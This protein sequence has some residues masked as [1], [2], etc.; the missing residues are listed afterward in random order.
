MS[1]STDWLLTPQRVAVHRPTATAVVADLHLG[2][3]E[4]RQRSGEAVP[5]RPLDE[6]LRGLRTVVQ[7]HAVCRLIV[8]GDLFEDGRAAA[9]VALRPWLEGVGLELIGVVPGNHD[10]G[11]TEEW[12]LFPDGIDLGGWRIV[13][14][15]GPLPA[16]RVVH[17]HVH[18][19]IRFGSLKAACYLE[20]EDR[21]VLP[22]F[23]PDAAGVNVLSEGRWRAYRCWVIAGERVLDFGTIATL[24]RR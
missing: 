16:G 20:S 21:L 13:H 8:A 3:A 11:L 7:R 22:A 5:V 4:A 9:S 19:C 10:R 18:P 15:D 2:Y 17:G 6:V 14:G 1:P 24:R 12:P 23:S